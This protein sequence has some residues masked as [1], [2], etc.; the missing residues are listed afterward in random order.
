MGWEPPGPWELHRPTH[1]IV[2]VRECAH[3]CSCVFM[4]AGYVFPH[5]R[6][7]VFLRA[8]V[9]T[10]VRLPPAVR[11]ACQHRRH[12]PE[13]MKPAAPR[14]TQPPRLPTADAVL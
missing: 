12:D 14:S 13:P 4:H 9:S 1:G 11:P 5:V 2:G 6:V 3:V 10:C 8:H 7:P